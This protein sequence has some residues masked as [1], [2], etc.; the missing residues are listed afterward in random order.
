MSELRSPLQAQ[1]VQWLV[2][3]GD[4][5]REGDVV[6]ILEAMKMEHE[7]RSPAAGR[8][9]ERALSIAG[10]RD[11]Y[12]I[13]HVDAVIAWARGQVEEAWGPPGDRYQ[14]NYHV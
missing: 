11:P 5:V 7:L 10:I 1:V 2:G 13:A 12:T 3:P 6:V 4:T 8:V 14:L 9:G